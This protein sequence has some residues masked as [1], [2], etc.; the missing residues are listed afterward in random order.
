MAAA[1][2][3]LVRGGGDGVAVG[4]ARCWFVVVMW[5]PRSCQMCA[6]APYLPA[7][8]VGAL[9]RCARPTASVAR[10]WFVV[11]VSGIGRRGL[12]VIG[13]VL[14]RARV[15]KF[16][17]ARL[18]SRC[19]ILAAGSWSVWIGRRWC[20]ATV[21]PSYCQRCPDSPTL[22]TP[23]SFPCSVLVR[24]WSVWWPWWSPCVR[25]IK[26]SVRTL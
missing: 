8:A 4:V 15:W 13:A 17:S 25:C 19:G 5:W 26:K 7:V 16:P 1:R 18:L 20:A 14:C 12:A 3:R 9:Q 6:A 23:G 21:R 2:C 24:G 10:G 22:N 11:V